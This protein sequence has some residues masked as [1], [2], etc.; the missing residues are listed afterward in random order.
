MVLWGMKNITVNIRCFTAIGQKSTKEF[1]KS[2]FCLFSLLT[3][4]GCMTSGTSL[5]LAPSPPDRSHSI[6]YTDSSKDGHV[7]QEGGVDVAFLPDYS[8]SVSSITSIRVAEM[9]VSANLSENNSY[10]CRMKD[11]FDRKAVLAYEWDRSRLSMDVDGVNMSDMGSDMAIRIEYKLRIH[12]EKPKKAKCR[13]GAKWQGLIGTG[14]HELFVREEDTVWGK[15][16]DIR[17]NPLKHISR[18]F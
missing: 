13:A 15:V 7:S 17:K 18:I 16:R 8:E 5:P 4:S 1:S 12:P 9:D 11:R 2:L 10:K 6:S 14:Y 3:L